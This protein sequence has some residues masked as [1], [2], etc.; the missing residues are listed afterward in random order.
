[1]QISKK[2]LTFTYIVTFQDHTNTKSEISLK[3]AKA[4]I[5]IKWIK[6]TLSMEPHLETR[7]ET[8]E[9]QS[10]FCSF[11]IYAAPIGRVA[12][13]NSANLFAPVSTEKQTKVT[14]PYI[15]WHAP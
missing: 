13:R 12:T 6:H 14:C 1:M 7:T 15:F 8:L 2:Y 9:V 10:L 4:K 5:E 3:G 11:L